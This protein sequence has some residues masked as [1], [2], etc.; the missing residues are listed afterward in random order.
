GRIIA[1][2]VDGAAA[3]AAA[4]APAGEIEEVPLTRIRRTIAR[5]LTEAWQVPVFQLQVSADMTRANELVTGAR[6]LHPD[7]RVSVTDLLTKVCASA[8]QRHPDVNVSFTD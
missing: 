1:E 8:L 2:D 5:R 3:P 4:P 7:V 6:E